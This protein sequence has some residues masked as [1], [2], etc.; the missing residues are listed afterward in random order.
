MINNLVLMMNYIKTGYYYVNY[1]SNQR[2]NKR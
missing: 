1:V 2:N